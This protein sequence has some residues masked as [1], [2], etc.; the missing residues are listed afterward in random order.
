MLLVV[1]G[2]YRFIVPLGR[3]ENPSFSKMASFTTS[4]LGRETMTL[5]RMHRIRAL[6]AINLNNLPQA[7]HD[8]G[9]LSSQVIE[10]VIG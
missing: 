7:P 8:E 10:L 4:S 5:G 2:R 6:G 3:I 1:Y 9:N